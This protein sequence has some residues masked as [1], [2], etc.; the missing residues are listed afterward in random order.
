MEAPE[1]FAGKADQDL[2]KMESSVQNCRLARLGPSDGS[3]HIKIT[4]TL[5]LSW[6]GQV[7]TVPSSSQTATQSDLVASDGEVV[8]N[9]VGVQEALGGLS[10]DE[11]VMADGLPCVAP[12]VSD[13]T[14][15]DT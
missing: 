2:K 13:V 7:T 8:W 12:S 9:N 14:S 11:N 3:P 15:L 1:G 6:D 10:E 4:Q 5:R